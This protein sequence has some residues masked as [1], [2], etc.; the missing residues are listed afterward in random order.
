MP[1]ALINHFEKH[2]FAMARRS[3]RDT[4]KPLRDTAKRARPVDQTDARHGAPLS[5][6]GAF[7]F[8]SVFADAPAALARALA[9]DHEAIAYRRQGDERAAMLARLL[10]QARLDGGG[11]AAASGGGA[12]AAVA[13]PATTALC[14]VA[15]ACDADGGEEGV[16][17]EG[18]NGARSGD[19]HDIHSTGR[20]R[21]WLPRWISVHQQQQQQ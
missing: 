1:R 6:E 8:S 2:V 3:L 14:D 16:G 12:A 10:R 4:A 9:C 18:T 17:P 13:T 20:W 5:A 7:D 11:A 15:G 21:R 19:T